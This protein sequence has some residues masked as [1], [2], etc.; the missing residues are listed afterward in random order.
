VTRYLLYTED[1]PTAAAKS[2]RQTGIGRY[3]AD[4]ASGLADLGHEISVLTGDDPEGPGGDRVTRQAG[5]VVERRGS[6][7]RTLV[8]RLARA[9]MLRRRLREMRP[10]M[11]LVGDPIAHQVAA[12]TPL[13]LPYCPIFYG[14]E[15]HVLREILAARDWSLRRAVLR[16]RLAAYLRR[17]LEPV[18]ISRFTASLFDKLGVGRRCN[19]IVFPAISD[20]LLGRPLNDGS[21]SLQD[22]STGHYEARFITVARVSERKNQLQ[23]LEVLADLRRRSGLSF[24]YLIVGNVDSPAHA[25]YLQA[26]RR[27]ADNEGLGDAVKFVERATDEEKID[28]I[29]ASDVFV[30]LSR[31]AGRSVEGFGISVIEA[32]SRGKPVVVS[33][34]GGMPETVVP[35]ETGF[36]V[37]V[38]AVEA[39]AET[40]LRLARNPELRRR[41][42][43]RGAEFVRANF[44]PRLMAERLVSQLAARNRLGSALARQS[45]T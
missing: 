21:R 12:L 13:R 27:L 25:G 29:D 37:S 34:Q 17:A 33:D 11:L 22:P 36:V 30:M 15:L 44:T 41:L 24:Q 45:R 43:A 35:G 16:R 18:C 42:G 5:I 9:S 28:W 3:C 20:I 4:L 10:D 6:A 31:G 23:V 14:T 8:Q 40:L 32:S 2:T 26:I 7:P 38:D 1:Y 19:V 39:I